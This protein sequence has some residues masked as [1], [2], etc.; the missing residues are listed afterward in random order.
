MDFL[1]IKSES[2]KA[3]DIAAGIQEDQKMVTMHLLGLIRMGYVTTPEKGKYIP[4][5]KG[6]QATSKPELTKE[7][8]QAILSFKPHDQAF[9][10]Y[11]DVGKPMGMHAHTLRDFAN[12]IGRI[13]PKSVEFHVIRGDFQ[14]WFVGIGDTELA[15]KTDALKEK[16]LTGEALR[17]ELSEIMEHRYVDLAKL[18]GQPV[19]EHEHHHEHV[20]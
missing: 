17:S 5:Q 2:Q 10:F 7:Q 12:K 13:D 3:A 9:S 6:K 11:S 19:D 8:A 14:A 1:L 16:K 4:T 15:K 18:A 20:H